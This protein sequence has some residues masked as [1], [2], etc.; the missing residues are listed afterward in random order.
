MVQVLLVAQTRTSSLSFCDNSEP[1]V[2]TMQ[3]ELLS[4]PLKT[5]N[6]E[7]ESTEEDACKC[8]TLERPLVKG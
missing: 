1:S 6:K 7:P 3:L 8:S 2:R 5:K 4:S